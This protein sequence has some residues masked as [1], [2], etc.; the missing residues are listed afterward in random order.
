MAKRVIRE[1]ES[2]GRARKITD[3]P[4]GQAPPDKLPAGEGEGSANS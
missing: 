4:E 1:G 3:G 2:L